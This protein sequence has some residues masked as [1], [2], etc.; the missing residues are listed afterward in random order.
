MR[1]KGWAK[2][3]PKMAKNKTF[4]MNILSIIIPCRT[5]AIN[6]NVDFAAMM[7]KDV[8][9]ATFIS[10]L[11]TKTKAGIIKNPPPAP[12][13]PVRTPTIRPSNITI[14]FIFLQILTVAFSVLPLN[15]KTPDNIM[16]KENKIIIKL[17]DDIEP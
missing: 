5:S 8:P 16:S 7:D 2:N 15:I 9:T 10:N 12:T 6:P 1:L 13:N 14:D 3:I 4:S 11:A 17:L